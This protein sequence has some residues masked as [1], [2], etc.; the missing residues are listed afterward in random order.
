MS[1]F[2]HSKPVN[3]TK[4][5]QGEEPKAEAPRPNLYLDA[6][7]IYICIYNHSGTQGSFPA[8]DRHIVHKHTTTHNIASKGFFPAGPK[9]KKR[10]PQSIGH[11]STFP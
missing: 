7:Y 6:L 1:T 3:A 11:P 9:H 2:E 8:E 5:Q 4:R 10:T